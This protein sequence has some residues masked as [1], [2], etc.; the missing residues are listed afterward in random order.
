MGDI[1]GD[2]VVNVMDANQ[3]MLHARGVA[4][5]EGY[6]YDCAN[7]DGDEAVNVIDANSTILHIRGQANLW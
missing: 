6:E 2:G 3:I 1:N 4:L 7:I 5:L